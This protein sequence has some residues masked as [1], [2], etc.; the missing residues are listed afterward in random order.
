MSVTAMRTWFDCR[1][2]DGRAALD[3]DRGRARVRRVDVDQ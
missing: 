2:D 1:I 3:A